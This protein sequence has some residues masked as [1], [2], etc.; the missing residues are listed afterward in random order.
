[1]VPAIF[2]HGMTPDEG[3]MHATQMGELSHCQGT[4]TED[5]CHFVDREVWDGGEKWKG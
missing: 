5:S 4:P 2:L 1:M 3:Q